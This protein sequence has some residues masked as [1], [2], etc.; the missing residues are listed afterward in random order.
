MCAVAATSPSEV[1]VRETVAMLEEVLRGRRRVLE[2]GC[3]DGEVARRLGARGFEVTAMDRALAGCGG[4]VRYVEA[5]FVG[6][7]V[8]EL[9]RFDA[10]VF[11]ASLHHVTPLRRAVERAARM[12][13]GGV[14]VV[15]DFDVDAPDRE[16]A[17]WFYAAQGERVADPLA[18][19]RADHEHGLHTGERMWRE[20]A[21]VGPVAVTTAPYLYRYLAR[22]LPAGEAGVR[23]AEA[24]LEEERER[25][26][27]GA[28]V[29]VGLRLIAMV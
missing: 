16:T 2:V 11:T 4:R 19:W 28:I 1:Q 7:G 23:Q 18:R 8:E 17:W 29:A 6:E 20:L 21:R 13:R 26:A 22:G 9:G 24:L 27:E 10:V 3:G 14:I 25:I 5:D 15:D 12:A